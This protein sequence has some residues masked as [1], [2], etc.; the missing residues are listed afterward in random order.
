MF[1]SCNQGSISL[2]FYLHFLYKSALRSFSIVTFWLCNFAKILAQKAPMLLMIMLMKLTPGVNFTNIIWAAFTHAD[3]QSAKKTV[4]LS[5]FFA[6]SGSAHAKAGRK[7]MMKLTPSLSLFMTISTCF[8]NSP[9]LE[10][11]FSLMTQLQL[12]T[13]KVLKYDQK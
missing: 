4:K 11:F 9:Q 1:K 7:T 10:C 12:L 3:P 6:L 5:V 8:N 2:T 13:S